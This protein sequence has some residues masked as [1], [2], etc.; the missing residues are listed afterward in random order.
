MLEY[1]EYNQKEGIVYKNQYRV[2]FC[3][4]YRRKVLVNGVDVRLKE[5]LYETAK[6]ND[7]TLNA[8]NVMSD[9]V[10][11]LIEV[12]PRQSVHMAIRILKGKTSNILRDEFPWLKSKI[13]SLWTRS[14]FCYTVGYD[15]EEAIRQYFFTQKNK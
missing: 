13:P 12:D 10:Q 4:K 15:S 1:D 3:P 7:I 8:V 9:Q 5:L 6:E 2:V 11:L 14:Y